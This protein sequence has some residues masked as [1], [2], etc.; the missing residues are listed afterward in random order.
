MEIKNNKRR[1]QCSQCPKTYS[2]SDTLRAHERDIHGTELDK[3]R[4]QCDVCFKRLGSRRELQRHMAVHDQDQTYA[5]SVCS[6][7]F[8][9]PDNLK[10]HEE[11]HNSG[12]FQ[13]E[14]ESC[15][16]VFKTTLAYQRHKS[17]RTDEIYIPPDDSSQCQRC[18]GC[19]TFAFKHHHQLV[20]IDKKD[21]HQCTHCLKIFRNAE[22]PRTKSRDGWKP[23]PFTSQCDEL[24]SHVFKEHTMTGPTGRYGRF[25][26]VDFIY[27]GM[28]RH[29]HRKIGVHCEHCHQLF[30]DKQGCS[31]HQA[32]KH[33][34]DS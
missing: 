16:M 34:S 7:E 24:S 18:T 30:S 33:L 13:C 32:T 14:D 20:N 27:N 10:V 6:K 2:R 25:N 26:G 21:V 1:Y 5:C 3:D 15:K 23:T 8:S 19:F 29:A 22:Y 28:Y 11:S 31:R 9:R 17:S 12:E 4:V